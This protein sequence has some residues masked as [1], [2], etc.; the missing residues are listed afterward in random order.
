MA[1]I[2]DVSDYIILRFTSQDNHDLNTLKHQKLLYYVQA[3][4]LAFTGE[5]MFDGKFQAWVHGPVNREIYDVY[6]DTKG[7]YSYFSSTDALQEKPQLTISDVAHIENVMEIYGGFSAFQLETMTHEEEPWLK[8]RD[9]FNSYQRCEVNIDESLM[10][11]YY[12][13]RL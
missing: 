4:H 6:K 3:W 7:L 12:K 1:T 8:A 2:K 5:K 10:S 11:S 13:Q 9:G